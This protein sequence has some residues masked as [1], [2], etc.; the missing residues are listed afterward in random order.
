M[1]LY[2][3]VGKRG[4]ASKKAMLIASI[5]RYYLKTVLALF[6]CLI[7]ILAELMNKRSNSRRRCFVVGEDLFGRVA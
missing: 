2:M 1:A 3:V 5:K 7:L 4:N 6:I